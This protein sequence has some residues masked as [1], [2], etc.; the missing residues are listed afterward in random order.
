MLFKTVQKGSPADPGDR[1]EGPG[2]GIILVG[3]AGGSWLAK[4]YLLRRLSRLLEPASSSCRKNKTF[5]I[6]FHLLNLERN[7]PP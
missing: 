2:D 6:S 7:G 3:G 1:A 4:M 5:I